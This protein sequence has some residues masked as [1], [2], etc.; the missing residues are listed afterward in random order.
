MGQNLLSRKRLVDLW[1]SFH[2]SLL[3]MT[4]FSFEL[5]IFTKDSVEVLVHSSWKK[6]RSVFNL[7]IFINNLYS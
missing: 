2:L 7:I 5:I 6:F 4:A 3:A 1:V